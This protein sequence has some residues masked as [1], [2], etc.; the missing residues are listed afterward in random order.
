MINVGEIISDPDFAQTYTVHRDN[1]AWVN[2]R[3]STAPQ[4]LQ[5]YGPVFPAAVQ[6]VQMLPE[7]DRVTG[8]MTFYTTSDQ[9]FKVSRN[10][11]DASGVSDQIEWRGEL[12]KILQVM[13][14]T[15]YGYLKAIG[16]RLSGD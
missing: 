15:D 5:F 14:Y 7:G 4:R 16:T 12:Y 11:S 13:P 3:W 10:V 9:P 2:G 6:D 8:L 1:G